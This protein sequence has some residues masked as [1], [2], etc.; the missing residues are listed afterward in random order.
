MFGRYQDPWTQERQLAPQHIKNNCSCSRCSCV[1]WINFRTYHIIPL[2][3]IAIFIVH[4]SSEIFCI[5]FPLIRNNFIWFEYF[6]LIG[7]SAW[8]N[9][10]NINNLVCYCDVSNIFIRERQIQIVPWNNRNENRDII[11]FCCK[12]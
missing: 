9:I 7:W 2:F 6:N 4:L 8:S 12:N 11:T 5:L 10:G 3:L 1:A